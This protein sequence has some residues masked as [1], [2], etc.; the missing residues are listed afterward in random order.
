MTRCEKMLAVPRPQDGSIA[1][2]PHHVVVFVVGLHSKR[3]CLHAEV[4][5]NL[6]TR[7][8]HYGIQSCPCL[9]KICRETWRVASRVM[10][11]FLITTHGK[12]VLTWLKGRGPGRDGTTS[13]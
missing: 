13:G 11:I 3:R 4:D 7:S 10:L 5:S 1:S 12:G 6:L 2:T 8:M 9:R